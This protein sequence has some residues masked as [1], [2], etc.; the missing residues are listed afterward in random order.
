MA[1]EI[2]PMALEI[3]PMALEISPMAPGGS[4]RNGS[5]KQEGGLK[6]YK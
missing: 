6:V 1:L 5:G 2:S 4:N 3:S